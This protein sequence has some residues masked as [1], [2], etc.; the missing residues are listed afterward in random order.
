M[1]KRIVLLTT[2]ISTL[3][4][5]C[6]SVTNFMVE[7]DINEELCLSEYFS[8]TTLVVFRVDAEDENIEYKIVDPEEKVLATKQGNRLA[9]SFTTYTGGYY[10]CCIK[11]HSG[12]EQNIHF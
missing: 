3:L 2:L 4:N 9:E 12:K 7:M 6:G 10:Q 11:N 8:D 5:L 1:A